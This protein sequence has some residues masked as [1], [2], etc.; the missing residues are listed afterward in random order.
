MKV[1]GFAHG[2]KLAHTKLSANNLSVKI[3]F[4]MILRLKFFLRLIKREMRVLI[5]AT[6]QPKLELIKCYQ[7][8]CK[9]VASIFA[10]ESI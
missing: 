10:F 4:A 7:Q 9:E 5:K 6:E 3:I 2:F 8:R 1:F